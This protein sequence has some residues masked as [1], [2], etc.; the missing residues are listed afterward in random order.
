MITKRMID[1]D[2]DN[3]RE[4]LREHDFVIPGMWTIVWPVLV[5]YIFIVFMQAV[6][7]IEYD[8]ETHKSQK[9]DFSSLYYVC[10]IAFIAAM[11]ALNGRAR[12][13]CLPEV[14]RKK[15]L[16]VRFIRRKVLIYTLLWMTVFLGTGVCAL[17]TPDITPDDSESSLFLG[18]IILFFLFNIDMARFELSALNKLYDLWKEN[19]L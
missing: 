13:L 10:L 1:E 18:L 12:Y 17:F 7:C 6:F 14:V 4:M 11:G 2:V 5:F 16:I 19:K 15:S 8:F 3:V 9:E